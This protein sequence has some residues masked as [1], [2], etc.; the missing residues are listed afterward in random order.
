MKNITSSTTSKRIKKKSL[1]RKILKGIAIPVVGVFL[2][3]GV[4]VKGKVDMIINDLTKIELMTKSQSAAYQ[5]NTFFVKYTEDV[6]QL[7]INNQFI[8]VLKDLKENQLIR[9]TKLYSDVNDTI[10]KTA[11]TDTE[12][13]LAVWIA[14][15]KTGQLIQS[16]GYESEIGWDV[17]ARPWY[18]V[19]ET[20]KPFLT[21]P[22]EDASTNK[23]VVTIAAPIIEKEKE[24]VIGAVGIDISL[25]SLDTIMSSYKLGENGGF[26]LLDSKHRILYHPDR[27]AVQKN[28]TEIGVSEQLLSDMK[29]DSKELLKYEMEGNRYLGAAAEIGDTEWTVL[30]AMPMS[31]YNNTS[32]IV[33]G[34]T[35][36]VFGAGIVIILIAIEM[37]SKAIVK[38]LKSLQYAAEQIAEGNLEIEVEINTEDE[39]GDVGE[40]I[41]QTVKRLKMYMDYID[42]IEKIL[43]QIGTGNLKFD[44]QH[45]YTGEF[46]KVKTGLLNMQMRLTSTISD[47]TVVAEQVSEGAEQIAKV[48]Q[49]LATSS[50]EQSQ[51][52]EKLF[53]L[54][55]HITELTEKNG[56]NAMQANESSHRASE[57]LKDG[58]KEMEDLTYTINH[59]NEVSSQIK[60]IIQNI[61]EIASQ[62]NLLALN[63]SI[64]AARAGEAGKGFAVVAS[65]V[66]HLASQSTKSSSETERLIKVILE[67]IRTGNDMTVTTAK[68]ISDV[69]R[70]ENEV[71]KMVEEIASAAKQQNNSMKEV[72]KE[73]TQIREGVKTNTAISEK[74]VSASQELANQAK[75]LKELVKEFEIK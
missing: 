40:A 14:D 72:S 36:V 4:L 28:I 44:L 53:S 52:I 32:Y 73:T 57:Y 49:A 33:A 9:E 25:E 3:A 10:I 21:E 31:E 23:M 6:R 67:A 71:A 17:Q 48:A 29:A 45:D 70:A 69:L 38:P 13:I 24:N 20:R 7:A 58:N 60:S 34:L 46:E 66:E 19:A 50:T 11:S 51:S 15:F 55:N 12:N 1:A 68:T 41:K 75:H 74:S 35:V 65:E 26:I 2:L 37:I 27:T 63:A 30:S 64:E 18:K 43:N 16:N 39:I 47:I 5:I 8:S 62:T 22:Y 54:I 61:D 56:E 42:E 59:I